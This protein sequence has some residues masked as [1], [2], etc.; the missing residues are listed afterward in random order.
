M[1]SVARGAGVSLSL[2]DYHCDDRTSLIRAA[3]HRIEEQDIAITKPDPSLEPEE[4]LRGVPCFEHVDGAR[5]A[6]GGA[7]R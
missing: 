6:R 4:R 7:P 2:V 3:L 5:A 1:R